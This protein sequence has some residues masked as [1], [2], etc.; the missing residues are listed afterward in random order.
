MVIYAIDAL[1]ITEVTV[2]H[3]WSLVVPRGMCVGGCE[4]LVGRS[5]MGVSW[6]EALW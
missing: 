4:V 2:G 6:R 3:W 1:G 5:G